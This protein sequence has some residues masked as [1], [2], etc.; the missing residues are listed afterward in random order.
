LDVDEPVRVLS[1]GAYVADRRALARQAMTS[2]PSAPSPSPSGSAPSAP[3]SSPPPS[4]PS[5]AS[6]FP[7]AAPFLDY[8]SAWKARRRATALQTAI[9]NL[10]NDFDI[11][12]VIEDVEGFLT[13][14]SLAAGWDVATLV[15]RS[16]RVRENAAWERR[17]GYP[18]CSRSKH[19]G[20]AADEAATADAALPVVATKSS[21]TRESHMPR[22]PPPRRRCG[23][24]RKDEHSNK[25]GEKKE[26]A[27]EREARREGGRPAS[28]DGVASSSSCS[29]STQDVGSMRATSSRSGSRST[30]GSD[31]SSR[32]ASS[33]SR[34]ISRSS[35]SSSRS[36]NL[37]VDSSGGGDDGGGNGG[38][39]GD[40]DDGS[41]RE[42]L[43]SWP[44]DLS[45]KCSVRPRHLS[46]S[47]L[48]VLERITQDEQ[49]LFAEALRLNF[50]QK[51]KFPNFD[52][53]YSRLVEANQAFGECIALNSRSDLPHQRK[54][55]TK[56]TSTFTIPSTAVAGDDA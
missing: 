11:V 9:T 5:P 7:A 3:P 35:S 44:T 21:S 54:T 15:Y 32:D 49:V 10:R 22:P 43:L 16:A 30:S 20:E 46:R 33:S 51:K 40:G 14:V 28:R 6:P 48:A 42:G 31:S 36:S 50:A 2:L 52:Q 13:K 34:S 23:E 41:S 26:E 17:H 29:S 27:A 24:K 19:G 38:D 55:A 1:R 18:P 45:S 56:L 39:D 12:G 37:D 47:A 53:E 25:G 8:Y 4:W